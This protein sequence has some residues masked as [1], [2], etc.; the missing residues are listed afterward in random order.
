MIHNF[1]IYMDNVKIPKAN[2]IEKALDFARGTNQILKH[3]RIS[4]AW[5]AAGA[6][7]GAFEAAHKYSLQRK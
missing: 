5:A 6:A 2:R 4:V 7:A 3:S 1:E